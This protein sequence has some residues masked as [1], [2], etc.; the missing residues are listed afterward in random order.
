VVSRLFYGRRRALVALVASLSSTLSST[1]RDTPRF[2][3]TPLVRP[4][5]AHRS[6]P[7]AVGALP[8]STQGVPVSP[9]FPRCSSVSS[10]GEQPPCAPV[11]LFTTLVFTRLL[12]GVGPRHR[13]AT[14]P[15]SA[16]SMAPAPA[17]CPQSSLPCRHE[18]TQVFP[19]APRAPPWPSPSSPARPRHE[20]ERR[21]YTHDRSPAVGSRTSIQD[22]VVWI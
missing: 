19:Q 12:A 7:R 13:W 20:V 18:H 14:P 15:C 8:P 4:V 21:H 5:R 22:L 11:S 1:A 17:L 6:S 3:L 10:R 9:P 16:P 2:A